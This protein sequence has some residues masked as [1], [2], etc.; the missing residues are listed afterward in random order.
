MVIRYVLVFGWLSMIGMGWGGVF[1]ASA[2]MIGAPVAIHPHHTWVASLEGDITNR[3]LTF[4]TGDSPDIH[5]TEVLFRGTY[6]ILERAN[7]FLTVGTVDDDFKIADYEGAQLEFAANQ[8]MAY[9]GG[10]KWT[11]YEISDVLFG[12]GGQYE[13]FS[14]TGEKAINPIPPNLTPFADATLDWQ[15]FRF[16]GGVQF[17]EIPYFVPYGGF[18]LSKIQGDL[19]ISQSTPPG[20]KVKENQGIGL[21]YGG[22][23]KLWKIILSAEIRLIAESSVAFSLQYPF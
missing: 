15:E 12:V 18:Y 21:F 3:E 14:L 23:F 4:D 13:R 17:D 11:V 5:L 8:A 10:F 2:G 19:K 7:V 20:T 16:F 9:G 1:E 22:D 6:G